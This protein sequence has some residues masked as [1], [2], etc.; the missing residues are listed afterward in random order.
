MINAYKILIRKH[1]GSRPLGRH[2][3]KWEN[4][5]K[6]DLREKGWEDVAWSG[7]G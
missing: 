3:H 4:N 1:E 7:L 5:I 2:G 6:M